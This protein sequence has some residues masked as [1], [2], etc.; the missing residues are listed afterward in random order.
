MPFFKVKDE[1]KLVITNFKVM[2]TSFK[3]TPQFVKIKRLEAKRRIKFNQP[4]IFFTV[5]NPYNRVTSFFLDKFRNIP[6]SVNPDSSYK[7]ERPQRVFFPL[8]G[9]P[10]RAS[11]VN[12]VRDRLLNT[13]FSDYIMMLHRIH[14]V[15]EHVNPQSWIL[16]H[17]RYYFAQSLD[18]ELKDINCIKIEDS[19]EMT[20]FADST[21]FNLKKKANSTSKFDEDLSFSGEHLEIVNNIYSE[22]FINFGYKKRKK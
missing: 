17:P 5:R 13:S 18:L 19:K 7:W 14:E 1:N 15:D 8:L 2:F 4:E 20:S 12:E 9:L 11:D 6:L 3:E 16:N 21:G 10:I 22:D